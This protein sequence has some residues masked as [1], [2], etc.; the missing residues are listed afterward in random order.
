MAEI[1]K[2]SDER[3]SCRRIRRR[4]SVELRMQLSGGTGR[5]IHAMT[6]DVSTFGFQLVF[7]S[8]T[9]ITPGERCQL[10]LVEMNS[11]IDGSIVWINE[12]PDAVFA[13]VKKIPVFKG[14]LKT[15]SLPELLLGISGH[16]ISGELRFTRGPAEKSIYFAK[17]EIVGAESNQ[18]FDDISSLML[19]T[20]RIAQSDFDRVLAMR[21]KSPSESVV[22]ILLRLG[23]LE[24]V[25]VENAA[26]FRVREIVKGLFG[27]S[28]GAFEFLANQPPPD[29]GHRLDLTTAALI[30][31]G[32]RGMRP[33]R[34]DEMLAMVDSLPLSLTEDPLHLYQ[35]VPLTK[36]ERS[37][38]KLIDGRDSIRQIVAKSGLP[39][40]KA[41]R[42][43]CVLL[44][45]CL[46]EFGEN[47]A[48]ESATKDIRGSVS[49]MAGLK[50]R[51]DKAYSGLDSMSHYEVLGISPKADGGDI[52]K[53]YY[54]MAKDFHPDMHH[55]LGVGYETKLTALF[56]RVSDAYD[57]LSDENKRKKYDNKQGVG[58]A[59]ESMDAGS[60][61]QLASN[62]YREGGVKFNA[63]QYSAAVE[64]FRRAMSLQPE[65][66]LYYFAAG[67]ALLMIPRRLKDAEEFLL[68]AIE[69]EPYNYNYLL[70]LG[71]LYLKARLPNRAKRVFAEVLSAEPGN[72]TAAK[73]LEA[74]ERLK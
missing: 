54:R 8:G 36:E 20:G 30:V 35:S 50:L 32:I 53:A 14:N 40:Q 69:K 58:V 16:R 43:V 10:T 68:K 66:G 37:F 1:N 47:I 34:I 22:E 48:D 15:T 74:A 9:V 21:R 28:E 29:G 59:Q 23:Y 18:E 39:E 49:E 31:V 11:I 73:G 7:E 17:G 64:L 27:W 3:R 19:R 44:G 67:K 6:V 4:L 38:L 63:G 60:Y 41:K 65:N 72:A 57:V 61:G 13:G 2:S 46:A 24:G 51:I 33:D 70:V 52:K 12:R 5:L 26:V 62:Y 45:I 56:G 71:H 42:A 55:K 25:A